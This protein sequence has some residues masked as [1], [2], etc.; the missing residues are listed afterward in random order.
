MLQQNETL[1][2]DIRN[3]QTTF[4]QILTSGTHYLT[5]EITSHVQLI[6]NALDNIKL[7]HEFRRSSKNWSKQFDANEM[8]TDRA[9]VQQIIRQG[10]DLIRELNTYLHTTTVQNKEENQLRELHSWACDSLKN[11]LNNLQPFASGSYAR[12]DNIAHHLG[13]TD[14]YTGYRHNL[15][16]SGNQPL[17]V[18]TVWADRKLPRVG[19]AGRHQ[20]TPDWKQSVHAY[21]HYGPSVTTT[22]NPL[23]ANHNQ[24]LLGYLQTKAQPSTELRRPTTTPN[25]MSRSMI[26]ESDLD[27]EVRKAGINLIY[28]GK[29]EFMDRYTKPAELPI[30]PFTINPQ[31]DFS[32][33]GR[34][35]ARLVPDSFNSEYTRS[36]VFPDATKVE[37]FPWLRSW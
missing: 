25:F 26:S 35:L 20:S 33:P 9:Y 17:N 3:L 19:T 11:Y 14:R 6:N 27:R 15:T 28:P 34:P 31:P 23:T 1:D 16:R 2:R 13:V 30:S 8:Q 22:S 5:Q 18:H 37:K 24:K 12:L 21:R 4:N 10:E 32:L 7:D 36:Y 29:T